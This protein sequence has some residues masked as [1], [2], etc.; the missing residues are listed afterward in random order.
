MIGP[1]SSVRTIDGHGSPARGLV[2]LSP[3][4][5]QGTS[6]VVTEIH[7]K[8][9]ALVGA[10]GTVTAIAAHWN[11]Q[12]STQGLDRAWTRYGALSPLST[13]CGADTSPE[14]SS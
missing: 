1:Q 9:F 7:P 10:G 4:T 11:A 12:L 8:T 13:R 3:A 5:Y 2:D 6:L 14:I